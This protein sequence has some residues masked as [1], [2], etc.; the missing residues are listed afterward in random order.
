MLQGLVRLEGLG[1]LKKKKNFHL[2]GSRTRDLSAC[3]IIPLPLRSRLP[4]LKN[5]H[6]VQK[7]CMILRENNAYFPKQPYWLDFVMQ[8]HCVSYEVGIINIAIRDI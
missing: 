7:F 2:M 8:K 5:T 6:Y 4:P 1:K 3:S